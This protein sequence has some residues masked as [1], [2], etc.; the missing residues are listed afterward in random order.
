MKK[1]IKRWVEEGI[2]KG[3]LRNRINVQRWK[4]KRDSQGE[5]NQTGK[6]EALIPLLV[7]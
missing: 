5:S 1:F 2:R 4:K 3:N 6:S 7:A